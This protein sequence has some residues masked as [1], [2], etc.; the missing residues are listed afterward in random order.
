MRVVAISSGICS[1]GWGRALL[2]V[3]GAIPIGSHVLA[4]GRLG[5]VIGASPN[6]NLAR[7]R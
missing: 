5:T 6:G 4:D 2:A 1:R 3:H 7:P